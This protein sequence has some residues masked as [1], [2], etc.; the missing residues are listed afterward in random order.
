MVCEFGS[1][2]SPAYNISS[3]SAN[4]ANQTTV[5]PNQASNVNFLNVGSNNL[6]INWTE[7]NGNGRCVFMK[8]GATGTPEPVN[9]STYNA[10]NVFGNGSQIGNTGWFCVYNS[11]AAT[12]AGNL[13]ITNLENSTSYIVMVCEYYDTTGSEYYI[14]NTALLNPNSHETTLPVSLSSF[15]VT[16]KENSAVLKWLTTSEINNSCF[17]IERRRKEETVWIMTGSVKGN[18]N[19][20]VPVEYSFED[21]NLESGSYAYRLKQIDYNGNFE[22]HVL[23]GIAE[24][25]QP[26][27]FSLDPNYPNPFNPETYIGFSIP[28]ECFVELA[29]Y[30]LSGRK[31]ELLVSGKMKAGYYK[32]KFASRNL[33][34]GVYVYRLAAGKFVRSMKMTYI[35]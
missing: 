18:G 35:K 2:V 31:V 14:N 25:K 6:T 16:V 20:N 3:S 4:T 33:A 30:D 27:S 7:G 34:S 5:L 32:H 11:A 22:Y 9:N 13:T 28:E 21:R 24:I 10:S 26:V 19:S 23:N 15:T 12:D 8:T 29:V 17:E 1:S